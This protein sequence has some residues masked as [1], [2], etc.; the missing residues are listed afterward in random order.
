[1]QDC[2]FTKQKNA[3]SIALVALIPGNAAVI[4][5]ITA[6]IKKNS[7]NNNIKIEKEFKLSFELLF[8]VIVGLKTKI[9][10]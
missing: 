2:T 5:V 6:P 7:Q 10:R 8:Y 9:L 1:M 4:P 3:E